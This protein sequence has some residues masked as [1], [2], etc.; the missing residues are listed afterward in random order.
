MNTINKNIFFQHTIKA[1]IT[2]QGVG[3]HSGKEASLTLKPALSNTGILFI[4]TDLPQPVS[5]PASREFVTHTKMATTLGRGAVQISTVE[6]LLCALKL[7]NVDNVV[8]EVSGPEIPIMDGSSALFCKAIEEVGTLEQLTPKK[9]AILKKRIEVRMGDKFAS[10]EPANEL[11]IDAKIEWSHPAIGTQE[12]SFVYQKSPADDISSARTFGFLKDVEQL[13]KMGLALGGSIEN[14][15]V[16][17]EAKVLN[18][19]GLRYPNEFVRHKVLDALGDIALS[20][21]SLLGKVTV[22]K[23]GHE[24]HAEL[25]QSIFS[26]RTNYEIVNLADWLKSEKSAKLGS[27]GQNFNALV[28]QAAF[29]RV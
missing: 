11:S 15:V 17:D 10:I 25:I 6:H 23:A 5:I 18:E 8:V 22:Y 24:L 13:K 12:F 4:R 20:P 27:H 14:A 9:V 2:I 26:D 1:D 3:L 7:M 16:L 21:V 19:E 29:A 28:N